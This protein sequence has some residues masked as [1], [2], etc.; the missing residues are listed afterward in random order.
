MAQQ[1]NSSETASNST[2]LES[3]G[4][5]EQL[6]T[7]Q[8]PARDQRQGVQQPS[9]NEE[10]KRLSLAELFAED[11]E[12]SGRESGADDDGSGPIDSIDKLAKRQGLTPEQVYAIKVPMAQGGEPLSIG[13]LKDRIGELVDLEQRE[14]EFDQRRRTGEGEMLRAQAEMRELMALI[15]KDKLQPGVLEKIRAKHEA[16]QASE[17]RAVLEH[18]PQWQDEKR[19]TE[20]LT[21]MVELLGD[22]GFPPEFMATVVDHRAVKMIRDFY[23]MD[24]R[25][26]SALAKVKDVKKPNGQRPSGK[27]GKAAARPNSGQSRQQRVLP[28]QNTR[29]RQLFGD[30]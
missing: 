15:P 8:R 30:K 27:N 23:L 3:S 11:G 10:P 19:R 22:Y 18:I 24:R 14:L 28:D 5:G 1:N 16:T 2:G 4:S 7:L 25:I 12:D 20:D 13:E 21:G 9:G 26:K 29:I 17:R 6:Q